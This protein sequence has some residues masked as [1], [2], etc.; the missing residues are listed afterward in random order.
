[1]PRLRAAY[2]PANPPPM[3]DDAMRQARLV[4]SALGAPGAPS[5]LAVTSS[6]RRLGQ[7][8]T[9]VGP[10]ERA[11]VWPCVAKL[12]LAGRACRSRRRTTSA[13]AS[14]RSRD[15]RSS[16]R[17]PTAIRANAATRIVPRLGVGVDRP[18]A[19]STTNVPS[20][21]VVAASIG[22][23]GAV[24]RTAARRVRAGDGPRAPR[25]PS[26]LLGDARAGRRAG[27]DAPGVAD[28][29]PARDPG[30]S[31]AA[32]PAR[33]PRRRPAT[34]RARRRSARPAPRRGGR[35]GTRNGEHDT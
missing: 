11:S 10:V 35:P 4:A 24:G 32:G 7:Q 33:R 8:A 16:T 17:R 29:D 12:D 5:M 31:A 21:S 6:E 28:P 1:M 20:G 2:S 23:G 30:P 26:R 27:R 34:C 3:I 15:R 13:S 18:S 19:A 9:R 22:Q 14:R 25:R